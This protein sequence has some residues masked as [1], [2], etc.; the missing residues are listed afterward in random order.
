[1]CWVMISS[2]LVL[3]MIPGV[4]FFYAGLARRKSALHVLFMVMLVCCVACFQWFF[5]GFSLTFGGQGSGFLGDLGNFGFRDVLAQ[6]SG[7]VPQILF[8]LFQGIFA[9]IT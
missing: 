2:A 6:P 7:P 1:M 5:W 8:A 9:M 3:L 4:G